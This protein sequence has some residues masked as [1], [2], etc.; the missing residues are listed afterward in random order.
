[1]RFSFPTTVIG[2]L[3]VGHMV[4]STPIST[5]T[6]PST[7]GDCDDVGPVEHTAHAQLVGRAGSGSNRGNG[8]QSAGQRTGNSSAK[9]PATPSAK[10]SV[11]PSITPSVNASAKSSAKST[12]R[13]SATRAV[14]SSLSSNPTT[15]ASSSPATRASS[16]P[17][18]RAG[19]A[20]SSS[21]RKLATSTSTST[22][23]SAPANI[24]MTKKKGWGE[25][26]VGF[27][28]Q[29][30]SDKWTEAK[31]KEF[32]AAGHGGVL[33]K[34]STIITV[35][36]AMWVPGKGAWLG[37]TPYEQGIFQDQVGN[38]APLL[39]KSIEKRN[40]TD[41]NSNYAHAEDMALYQWELLEFSSKEQKSPT[42]YPSG[43]FVTAYGQ[44]E[45]G[46]KAQAQKLCGGTKS[47]VKPTCEDT[48]KQLK[49][50]S[51]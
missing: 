47:K 16:S 36:A 24:D 21:T 30:A 49:I 9:P 51:G 32:A 11:K 42:A 48:F 40:V 38:F 22:P 33:K 12:T 13:S 15:R 5:N 28:K 7:H 46:G 25:T 44:L 2:I 3:A 27:K 35:V 34:N 39:A 17:T 14:G 18:T 45:K 29:E 23:T 4:Y 43:I 20:A 26:F 50:K 31:I 8:R 10:S 19:S 41:K 6:L 1:M 37:S